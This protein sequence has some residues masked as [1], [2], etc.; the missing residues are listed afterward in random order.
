M[1]V[2]AVV[3]LVLAGTLQA[4][5]Y[6]GSLGAL[7]DGAYGLALL[8]KVVLVAAVVAL[9]WLNR[10]ALA[11]AST[12]GVRR[13]MRAEV[14]I[15]L[16]VLVATVVL[17]RAAP[18]VAA[19]QGPQTRDLVLGPMRMELV[20]EPARVGSNAFHLYLFDRRT[21]AQVDRVDEVLLYLTNRE[22]DLRFKIAVARKGPAHYE[23]LGQPLPAEGR[24]DVRVEVR[25]GEF[26]LYTARTGLVAR[27]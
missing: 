15:A 5:F 8:A 23:L 11:R 9:G 7:T 4:W 6:L 20:A 13:A 1:A 27:G 10:R 19:T 14:G 25:R 12:A 17:V 3:A 16:G 21:G 26:D 2:A 22:R 18:P 24:W